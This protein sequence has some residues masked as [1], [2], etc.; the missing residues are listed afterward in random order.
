MRV[1]WLESALLQFE[2]IV[3]HIADDKPK[4]AIKFRDEVNNKV[5]ALAA[6]PSTGRASHRVQGED[7]RELVVH[8]NYLV[9]Y[10]LDV[11]RVEIIA[12]IHAHQSWP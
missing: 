1:E 7:I 5:L 8:E 10:R 2:A 6:F 11:A 12:V 9:F 4:A 3:T